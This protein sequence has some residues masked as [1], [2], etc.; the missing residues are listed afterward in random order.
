MIERLAALKITQLARSFKSVAVTGPRQSG[1]T[2]LVRSLFPD[3]PYLSLENPDI[4]RFAIEDPRG[5]LARYEQGAIFDEVQRTP[6]LFSYLQ[7]ILDDSS[8]TGRFVLTG[9]NNFLLQ[10]NISQTL[11]GRVAIINLLPFS[12]AE[13]FPDHQTPPDENLLMLKGHYPPIYDPGIPPEDWF[14]NYLR[15]YIDRDVRQIKNITDL[16]VFERFI[17]LLAG[18]TGQELNLTS[19]AVDTGVDTKT[20]QSWIGILESSFII[21][22]LRPHFKN[23]NKTLIKRP[24]IYFYDTGLVCSLLGITDEE[25]L[26]LHP[27]RGSLFECLVVTELLKKRTNAGKPVNL[28]YWRDKTG[29]EVDVVVDN[30]LTLLPIEIKA[31]KTI[32]GEFFKSLLYWNKLSG[33]RKAYIIYAGNQEEERSNGVNVIN[34]FEMVKRDI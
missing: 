30:G 25:Q 7:E 34:W 10:Q 29:H 11:A 13:I 32:N 21:Y 14:P 17:R 9:S 2:T 33:E 28:Y 27:L 26:A 18:R 22:L 16:I 24:K 15:T 12:T 4:R 20:V 23:F 31:G 19:L 5:F 3:K 6:E 8:E 1:K